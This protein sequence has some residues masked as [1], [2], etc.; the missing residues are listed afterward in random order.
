VRIP[1]YDE[2]EPDVAI[3][4]G[5]DGDYR[6]RIPEAS[7]VAL[8]AEVC[9]TTLDEASGR[10]LTAYA[11]GGI[12]VYWIVNLVDRQIEVYTGP[13]PGGY[14]TRQDFFPGQQVPVVIEGRQVG[15]IA[16]DDVLP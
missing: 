11:K 1:A 15:Q 10:K 4:R 14:A 8:S 5:A 3:V 16:V 13:G 12:P 6:H 9:L 2:P 7:D